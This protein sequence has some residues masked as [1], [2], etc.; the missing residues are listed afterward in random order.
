MFSFSKFCVISA[1]IAS[2]LADHRHSIRSRM[3]GG[4]D[5]KPGDLPYSA[6]IALPKFKL[7]CGGAIISDRFVL[8]AAKCVSGINAEAVE[9]FTGFPN[10]TEKM[11]KVKNI[12]VHELYH[13]DKEWHDLALVELTERIEFSTGIGP[14]PLGTEV[15]D[16][17]V[18]ATA[19][20]S[21]IYVIRES[22]EVPAVDQSCTFSSYRSPTH[23]CR[24]C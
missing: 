8:T 24:R 22:I 19:S 20:G 18:A 13:P 11:Y 3:N 21:G 4:T 16:G 23:T 2:A 14:V 7:S 6:R 15:F 1:L 10:V 5:A 9:V 12:T 17:E